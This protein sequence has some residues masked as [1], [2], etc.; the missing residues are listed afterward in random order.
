MGRYANATTRFDFPDLSEDDDPIYVI[1][2][3]PKTVP[4][5]RLAPAG[6]VPTGPDG[7][8]ERDAAM[9]AS[10]EVM[11]GLVVDWHVYDA[12]AEDDSPPLPLPAT[13]AMLRSLPFEIVQAITDEIAKVLSPPT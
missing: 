11:A 13:V 5:E 8:P 7:K 12:T 2:R 9:N 3:N 1:I 6:D 4:A 10:F